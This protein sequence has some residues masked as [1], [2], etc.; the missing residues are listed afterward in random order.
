MSNGNGEDKA[1][2]I[3]V[4]NIVSQNGVAL[5][6]HIEGR[7][8]ETLM[9]VGL[10]EILSEMGVQGLLTWT[11]IGQLADISKSLRTLNASI[12]ESRQ[13]QG[14]KPNEALQALLENLVR[15]FPEMESVVTNLMKG[16]KG[17]VG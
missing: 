14:S 7:A 16:Q 17:T 6:R 9:Q 10:D 5:I 11:M 3:R 2:D 12:T 4:E 13:G 1:P 8:P 15:Q